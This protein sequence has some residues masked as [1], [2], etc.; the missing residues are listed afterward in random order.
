MTSSVRARSVRRGRSG[1][2]QDL[3]EGQVKVGG[4]VRVES[5]Q[6]G[7]QGGGRSVRRGRSVWGQN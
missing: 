7:G 1:W 6:G 4:R 2:G 3:C 5:G